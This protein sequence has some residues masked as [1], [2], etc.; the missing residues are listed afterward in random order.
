MVIIKDVWNARCWEQSTI[1]LV[2]FAVECIDDKVLNMDLD[3]KW[4][5]S[6]EVEGT[7]ENN[8]H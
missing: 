6:Q 8:N 7:G 3:E 5:N 4:N 2:N 1:Q